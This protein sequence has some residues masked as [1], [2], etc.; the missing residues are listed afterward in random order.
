MSDQPSKGPATPPPGFEDLEV[1]QDLGMRICNNILA[2]QAGMSETFDEWARY[3][4]VYNDTRTESS[5]DFLDDVQPYNF[6]L[7]QTRVD[8]LVDDLCDGIKSADPMF[9][10]R[11]TL[12]SEEVRG[13]VERVT[14]FALRTAKLGLNLGYAAQNAVLKTR[15]MLRCRYM[16]IEQDALHDAQDVLNL[17]LSPLQYSGLVIDSFRAE[18]V[19]VWPMYAMDL[20]KASMVGHAFVQRLGDVRARQAAGEYFDDVDIPAGDETNAPTSSA[21]S[22]DHGK[23]FYDL[24]I[25][26]IPKPSDTSY[27]GEDEA[28]QPEKRYRVTIHFVTKTIVAMEEYRLPRVWYFAPALRFEPSQFWGTKSLAGKAIQVQTVVN[29]AVTMMV[30]GAASAAFPN[31]IA[32]GGML[33]SQK[34]R[35]GI[36]AM[37]HVRNPLNLQT[38]AGNQFSGDPLGDLIELCERFAD[39]IFKMSQAGMGQNFAPSTTATAAAGAMQ[40][41]AAG[42][43][44]VTD[45]FGQELVALADFARYLLAIKWEEFSAFHSDVEKTYTGEDGSIQE[46]TGADFIANYTI[47]LNGEAGQNPMVTVQKLQTLLQ[48]TESLAQQLQAQ[49]KQVNA[50]AFFDAILNALDLPVNTSQLLTQAPQQAP[51]GGTGA[52]SGTGNQMAGGPPQGGSNG[53]A[54]PTGI[55]GPGPATGGGLQPPGGNQ[56]S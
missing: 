14:Q 1:R 22:N 35:M 19:V 11:S 10:F 43:S 37:T 23:I 53:K 36:G 13:A 45:N 25:R 32:S 29:D 28:K 56:P 34:V 2:Y 4:E 3:D 30:V 46:L 39:A 51:M 31:V 20:T 41:Q 42:M 47:A 7:I 6:P 15:G 18:D 8:A 49:G 55:A 5:L 33:E 38:V 16:D 24:L 26:A 50:S 52:D 17:N 44:A 27:S 40:G 12:V 9:V 54:Q 48:L 21:D